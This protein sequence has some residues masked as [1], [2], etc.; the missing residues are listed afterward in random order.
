MCQVGS[1]Q[2]S[3]CIVGCPRGAR[4]R[5]SVVM[6]SVALRSPG[7]VWLWLTLADSNWVWLALAGLVS[8]PFSGSLWLVRLAAT[9]IIFFKNCHFQTLEYLKCCRVF[10]KVIVFVAHSVNTNECCCTIQNLNPT[11]LPSQG[12][13]RY[14][15]E[16]GRFL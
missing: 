10:E 8:L 5:V 7:S 4:Q 15:I 13:M 9:Y 3:A 2:S 1:S 12:P 6:V 16:Y 14:R 11:I